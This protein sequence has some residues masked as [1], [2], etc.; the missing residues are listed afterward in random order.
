MVKNR[1]NSKSQVKAQVNAVKEFRNWEMMNS[2]KEIK[3]NHSKFSTS[4]IREQ[5]EAIHP[6]KPT[7]PELTN[8]L[9][10]VHSLQSP[11]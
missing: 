10:K 1:P 2:R 6:E 9:R 3:W 7:R 4:S 8:E 11:E 5:L